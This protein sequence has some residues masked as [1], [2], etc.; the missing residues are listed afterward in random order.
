LDEGK[1]CA[2]RKEGNRLIVRRIWVILTVAGL[3]AVAG[4]GSS[5][6]RD[7]QQ[8]FNPGRAAFEAGRWQEAVD[9]FTRFLAAHPSSP[10]R[11][12]VYYYRGL[13]EVRLSRRAEA[14]ADFQRAT[15]A[16]GRALVDGG[17]LF[18]LCD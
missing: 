17:P 15:R 10:A 9:A 5:V 4:C 11:G 13:A 2:R 1:F 16:A 12:E 18:G 8:D 7:A 3:L 14:L 6:T